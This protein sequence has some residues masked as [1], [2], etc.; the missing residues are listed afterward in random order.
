MDL[1]LQGK[2][3]VITGGS[4]GIGKAI[5]F[6]F[7]AEGANIATCARHLEPLRAVEDSIRSRNVAAFI[8]ECD[9]GDASSFENFLDAS[10]K[11]LGDINILV[12]NA[13]ALAMNNDLEAWQ[14]E[15]NVDL[16]GTVR[17]CNQVIP[18]MAQSGGGT[19]LNIASISGLEAG[20][21]TDFAYSAIKAALNSYTQKLAG[22]Y[23]TQRIRVNA[24]APGSIDFEGGFWARLKEQN[25]EVYHKMLLS[26]PWGRMGTPEEVADAALYLSSERASWITGACLSVDGGQ[27]RGN[28]SRAETPCADPRCGS[29]VSHIG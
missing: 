29:P 8:Q 10:K 13:S 24:I 12:N 7:A 19:I 25:P 27:Y 21:S 9:V 15:I 20:I 28:R 3:V 17:A 23:A 4:R 1:G 11:N 6:A 22:V 16:L 2:N 5:A 26:I 14:S 18:W